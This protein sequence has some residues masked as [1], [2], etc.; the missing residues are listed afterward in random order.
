MGDM[1]LDRTGQDWTGQ[2]S[3]GQHWIGQD[4]TGQDSIGQNR[5]GKDRTVLN[6]EETYFFIFKFSV[7]RTFFRIMFGYQIFIILC[8]YQ[9]GL[10]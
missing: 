8:W 10:I 5:T 2:D 1:Y 6:I 3:I 9:R 7:M 4:R